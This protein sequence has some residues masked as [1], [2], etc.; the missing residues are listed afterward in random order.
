MQLFPRNLRK[1]SLLQLYYLGHTVISIFQISL[2]VNH[3]WCV[4]PKLQRYFEGYGIISASADQIS[5][6]LFPRLLYG[7]CPLPRPCGA[8]GGNGRLYRKRGCVC[9][10]TSALAD[11]ISGKLFPRLLY[12]LCPP[13]RPLRGNRRKWTIIPQT[14]LRLWY[15]KRIGRPNS[16]GAVSAL[17]IRLCPSPR[18]CGATGG[19]G[20]LYRKRGCVCGITSASADQISGKLF[21]RLLYVYVHRL[22]PAGQPAEMDDYTANAVAFVV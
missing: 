2:N 14:R 8:T 20:R 13:P 21:L 3:I 9:G 19:N 12:V 6:K 7:L 15:N 18:P 4:N 17:I 11:Q 22:A 5:G 1:Y 16:R 10:I